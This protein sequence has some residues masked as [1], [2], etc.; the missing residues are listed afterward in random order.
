MADN[1]EQKVNLFDYPAVT[2]WDTPVEQLN[3]ALDTTNA[4]PE[5]RSLAEA[6]HGGFKNLQHLAASYMM[7][8]GKQLLDPEGFE[9][10]GIGRWLFETGEDWYTEVGADIADDKHRPRWKD[11]EGVGETSSWF[12]D[13]IAE[14]IPLMAPGV[15]GGGL[16]GIAAAAAGWPVVAVTGAVWGVVGLTSY[17]LNTGDAYSKQLQ[18]GGKIDEDVAD[19]AGVVAAAFDVIIPGVITGKVVKALGPK[20]SK[21][22]RDGLQKNVAKNLRLNTAVGSRIKRG[23]TYALVEGSTE[24]LQEGLLEASVNY[25]NDL[26][27]FEY[28]PEQKEILTE[29]FGLV[30]AVLLGQLPLLAEGLRE[31]PLRLNLR[32][33]MLK[34][35]LVKLQ[36]LQMR[37][38]Y[39]RRLISLLY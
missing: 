38:Y 30:L 1:Q 15:V 33:L 19:V 20:L 27:T 22:L 14:Q 39:L 24:Y 35:Q 25:V 3:Q 18:K 10:E 32:L 21:N 16:A 11:V 13:A 28:S 29:A 6:F 9:H 17:L 36:L 26:P 37:L 2:R 8:T 4:S 34:Q 7:K 23:I 31:K 5:E 12:A